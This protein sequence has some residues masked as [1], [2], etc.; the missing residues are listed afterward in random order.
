[1]SN[2]NTRKTLANCKNSE[3]LPAAMKA[4]RIVCESYNK[5]NVKSIVERFKESDTQDAGAML[6]MIM[7]VIGAIFTEYPAETVQLAAIAG[8]MT[9]EEA[10]N[11]PPTELF[12]I[13]LECALSVRV[14]DFFISVENMGGKNTDGIYPALIFLR[15]ISGAMNTSDSES[16]TN[17]NDLNESASNGDTLASA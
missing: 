17:T 2:E 16:Q 9:V 4:R 12:A 13:L 15:V 3:F 8:F 14:L 7:N 11:I 5:I 6:D 1:M 10:E